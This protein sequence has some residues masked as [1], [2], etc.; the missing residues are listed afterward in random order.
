[1]LTIRA[2]YQVQGAHHQRDD[3]VGVPEE[4]HVLGELDLLGVLL[5]VAQ[6]LAGDRAEDRDGGGGVAQGE[7]VPAGHPPHE[8]LHDGGLQGPVEAH[9]HGE[10]EDQP[11]R[12]HAPGLEAQCVHDYPGEDGRGPE[13]HVAGQVDVLEG[14]QPGEHDV[15][16]EAEGHGKRHGAPEVPAEG[17]EARVLPEVG[18]AEPEDLG[19]ERLEDLE[20]RGDDAGAERD[21]QEAYDR[22]RRARDHVV[23]A[24]SLHEQAYEHDGPDK[25]GGLGED[26]VRDPLRYRDQGLHLRPP[27]YAWRSRA[28]AS[29]SR[30]S[31][32]ST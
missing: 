32:L 24:L 16:E 25:E 18:L 6:V 13:H 17:L 10:E 19:P 30:I 27:R 2:P 4:S 22:L 1:V 11:G 20:R 14:A 7:V 12:V 23:H 29:A 21:E 8:G 3:D 28:G 5:L 9:D 31:S 15:Q 26:V